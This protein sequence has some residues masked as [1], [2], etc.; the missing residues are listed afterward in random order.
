MLAAIAV[1]DDGAAL[2]MGATAE[3]RRGADDFLTRILEPALLRL[4]MP[5]LG[6]SLELFRY[7]M[8]SG[9]GCA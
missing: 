2:V 7:T 8:V 3:E 5:T 1:D 4:R 9:W 6:R